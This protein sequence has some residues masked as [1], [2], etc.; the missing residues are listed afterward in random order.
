MDSHQH[1]RKIRVAALSILSNSTLVLLK[2]AV[3]LFI[4]SVAILSEA[5]HSGVDLVAALIAYVAVQASSKPAD[6]D[7]PFGHGKAEN[8]SGTI[9]AALIFVAAAWII[10]EAVDKLLDPQPI[11]MV[12]WGVAVMLISSVVNIAV[13][14]LLFRV[15]R[16]TES[17]AL[18]ADAW[19]LRT[20]VYTS[21]GV[22]AGLG[23]IWGGAWLAPG[24]NLLWLDPVAAITVALLIIGAAY[25]LTV[26]AA[27][28]LMDASIPPHEEDEIRTIVKTVYPRV[29]GF[30]KLRT[31]KSGSTRFIEFHAKVGPEMTVGDSHALMHDIT[32]LIERRFPGSH[33][34]IHTEP[35]D[36]KC[37][38]DC[39]GGC[40]LSGDERDM[41]RQKK[42]SL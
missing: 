1:T 37:D 25:R 24:V 5:I 12:G 32:H 9:E 34:T 11:T 41:V 40:L 19:H 33:I 30:H 42:S 20:D 18:E 39:I 6:E 38:V 16:D 26:T 7:H 28:D 3:G 35:C 21:F 14:E 36:G 27:R 23:I 29:H 8:I 2:L 22:M 31:R 10:F 13:S 15:A 17:V 4:G